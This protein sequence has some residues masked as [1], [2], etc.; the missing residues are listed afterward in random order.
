MIWKYEKLVESMP[1]LMK[2]VIENRGPT[3]VEFW[4]APKLKY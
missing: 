3:K 4:T 1:R 2:A